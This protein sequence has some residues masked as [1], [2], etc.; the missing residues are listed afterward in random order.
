MKKATIVLQSLFAASLLFLTACQKDK[1]I[2][3]DETIWYR[4]ADNDGLGNPL[5]SLLDC[6]QPFGYVSNPNDDDDTVASNN[7]SNNGNGL[8]AVV[9]TFGNNIDLTNLANYANQTI[10]NYINED[11]TGNNPITDAG[12]TLGRVLF[13]D[14]NLS[15][16]NSISCASCHQQAFAFGDNNLQS[17]GVAGQTG[18]HAMRLVNARFAEERRFFWDERANSL[19]TQTTMPIQNHVEMGFSGQD[20]DPN[21]ND[22]MNKLEAIPYYQEL[23]TFV[24]GDPVVTEQRM[25]RA[26]AQFIRSIQSFDAKYDQGLAQVNNDNAQFPNFTQLENMGKDLFMQPPN[27]GGAGCQ[28]CHRAPAFD[29]DNNSRNNGV[30]GVIGDPTAIDVT[31][32]R[33]PTLRDM[34][35]PAGQL[36]GPL[37]HD[38]SLASI[39]AVIDHYDHLN[40]VPGNTNLDNRLRGGGPGGNGNGQ[41]LNL[42][43]QEKSAL[44]AFLRTLGGSNVYTDLRWSDPFGE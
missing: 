19:E 38:G 16:D 32:T 27:Q 43:E 40:I 36:N 10:P 2:V 13:Y 39:E 6:E 4:D 7:G 35:N 31:I 3:C 34:F 17:D 44:V 33:S 25:Q 20:G 37:M 8:S 14:K 5:I 22:L 30:V 23:F 11:N 21:L 28:G 1:E 42:T 29:I 26:L 9:Q 41:N 12:A 15:V 24:Y 18:R